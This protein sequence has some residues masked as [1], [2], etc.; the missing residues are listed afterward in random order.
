MNVEVDAGEPDSGR[1]ISHLTTDESVPGMVFCDLGY[2]AC[3]ET[4]ESLA[5]DG[6][7]CGACG[8]ICPSNICVNGECMGAM[9]GDVVLVGHDFTNAWDGSAQAKVLVN[10][11]S[12][13]T[14]NPIRV[15]SYEDGADPAAVSQALELM[16]AGVH[17]RKV[18]ITHATKANLDSMS[19]ALS[20]DVVVLHDAGDA[21]LGV[22]WKNSLPHFAEKGGVVVALD[23]GNS[24]MSD[25]VSSATLLGVTGHAK[26]AE[27]THLLV[28]MP[29]DVVGT[30]VLSP[31]A[32]FGP[33][34]AFSG[35]ETGP[36]V[37]WVVR[38]DDP[39]AAPVVVHKSVKSPE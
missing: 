13:P 6:H 27:G 16:N 15:L 18:K 2:T 17:G 4:C 32:A 36:D 30:Q 23:G 26:L 7:N 20:Y 11:L 37:T 3:G 12:I 14:T 25:L 21:S 34:V 29:G 39:G 38:V 35:V 22:R 31:Y 8:K 10:A 1:S 28:S 5:D 19:L 33:P 9:A 24:H